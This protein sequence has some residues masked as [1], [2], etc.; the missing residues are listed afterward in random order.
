[1]QTEHLVESRKLLEAHAYLMK[2]EQWQ[3]DI[4]WQ[5]QGA[6]GIP[7][8]ELSTDDQELVSKYFSGVRK[9]GETLGEATATK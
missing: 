9:L 2:L 1:M 4:L 3:D 8:N 6:S 5:L 7:G